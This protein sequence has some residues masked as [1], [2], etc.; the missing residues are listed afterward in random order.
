MKVR[1][2][3]M[4][5]R[6]QWE[7]LINVK[8]KQ[9]KKENLVVLNTIQKD[10]FYVNKDIYSHLVSKDVMN[11]TISRKDY[12][13]CN[14]RLIAKLNMANSEAYIQVTEYPLLRYFY[15]FF[16]NALGKGSL[17]LNFCGFFGQKG[18]LIHLIESIPQCFNF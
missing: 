9:E 14:N 16:M 8:L 12:M 4:F 15:T 10:K 6:Y 1:Q 2:P 11:N 5:R 18:N 3:E 13:F 17:V 7:Q